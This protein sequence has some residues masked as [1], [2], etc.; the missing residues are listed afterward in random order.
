MRYA[1]EFL[2]SDGSTILG[3]GGN[4]G[5]VAWQKF[6][7]SVKKSLTKYLELRTK[8]TGPFPDCLLLTHVL[9]KK[10]RPCNG[11]DI[12]ELTR[13]SP[14]LWAGSYVRTTGEGR[15]AIGCTKSGG[16]SKR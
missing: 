14:S 10:L 1:N 16:A 5:K 11:R 3:K 6:N 2:T 8:L 4:G 15:L 12:G 7:R 13:R 9:D